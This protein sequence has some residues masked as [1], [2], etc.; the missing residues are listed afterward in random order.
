MNPQFWLYWIGIVAVGYIILLPGIIF[1]VMKRHRKGK[2]RELTLL[3]GF[4]G[5][6]G[7]PYYI[8]SCSQPAAVKAEVPMRRSVMRAMVAR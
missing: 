7:C 5:P 1:L 6:V 3:C 8:V 2:E 4:P